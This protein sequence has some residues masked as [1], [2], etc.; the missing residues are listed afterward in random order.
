MILL[1]TLASAAAVVLVCSLLVVINFSGNRRDAIATLATQS[2]MIANTVTA[3]VQFDDP[4]AGKETLSALQT[5]EDVTGATIYRPDGRVFASYT[6][7]DYPARRFAPG[8]KGPR[9]EGDWLIFTQPIL[10]Q[11]QTLGSLVVAYDMR[12]IYHHLWMNVLWGAVLG[13]AATGVAFIIAIR[14]ERY[15]SRPI[16]EL[17]GTANAVAKT[18]DYGQR[19][20]K[21]SDDELGELTDVFNEMLS[22]IEGAEKEREQLLSAERDA[23][24]QAEAAS[25]L[26]DEFLATVSHELRTPLNAI[27]GW[28]QLLRRPRATPHDLETGLETIERNARVQ[29]RLIEDLLDIG[30]II[31][32]KMR[33]EVQDVDLPAVIE[34]ALDAVR[35]AAGAKGVRH[36][37]VLEASDATVKGDPARLQ[38]VVWNLLAN[39]IKFTPRGGRVQVILHR[40]N[41]HVEIQVSDTGEGIAPEFLPHV[42]ERFRQADGSISRKHG[43][44]GL[45]LAIVKQLTEM[46]GGS[47]EARS[48]G[49]GEG[50]T[51]VIKLPVMIFQG[52]HLPHTPAAE[53]HVAEHHHGDGATLEGLRVLVVD[54]EPDA[55]A[56]IRHV[57]E[58]AGASVV[59]AHTA[60]E[61]LEK[62]HAERPHVLVSDIGMPGEDG[63]ALIRRVRALPAADGGNT[64]AAAVTALARPEDRTRALRAG[65]Q[66]HI[67]KPVDPT[68]MVLVVASLSPRERN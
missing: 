14:L 9:P 56:I 53:P 42:F 34:A 65:Y 52:T 55:V 47:V 46:H 36:Q 58:D 44:L 12:P 59:T 8:A 68:E 16:G 18:H 48:G 28:S 33:L 26:K 43:G 60:R 19:A 4:A 22:Q 31:T 51:F 10:S 40:V 20:A 45:G 67:A 11:G 30:R 64:P 50:A 1:T 3:A 2:E 37:P 24:S 62:L 49:A 63:Y 66:S 25:R 5:I 27:L 23:R 29:T 54:D 39:A 32:G 7:P 35:P 17:V 38:Q 13:I 6:H 21:F 15:L 57:L 61:A 41:S